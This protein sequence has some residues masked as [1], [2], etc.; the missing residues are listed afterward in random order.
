[1]IDDIVKLANL[2]IG[3][4][5]NTVGYKRNR[6]AN[7]T[8]KNENTA[9]LGLSYFIDVPYWVQNTALGIVKTGQTDQ[10]LT[11]KSYN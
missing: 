10:G 2:Y 6:D 1:M 8:T 9:L 4:K 7:H 3:L 11:E 5:R